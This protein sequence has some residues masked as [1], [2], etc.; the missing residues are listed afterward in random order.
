MKILLKT[1]NSSWFYPLRTVNLAAKNPIFFLK[2][3]ST[4]SIDGCEAVLPPQNLPETSPDVNDL[5]LG[6]SKG[7]TSCK[8]SK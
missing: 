5:P 8:S 2:P 1:E 7:S 4:I 3:C 6:V